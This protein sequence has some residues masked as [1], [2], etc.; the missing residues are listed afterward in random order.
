[1]KGAFAG[2]LFLCMLSQLMQLP[3]GFCTQ[4]GKNLQV[5]CPGQRA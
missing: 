4:K 1:M 2:S 3:S 5:A